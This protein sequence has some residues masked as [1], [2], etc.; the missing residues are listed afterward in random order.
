MKQQNP[1]I[2]A[3]AAETFRAKIMERKG[4]L[5]R[6]QELEKMKDSFPYFL[7][8]YCRT[9]DEHDP[10]VS[11]KPFPRHDFVLGVAQL[12]E[13][14]KFLAIQKSRQLMASWICCAFTL[15]KA[16]FTP[17]SLCFVQ[18]KK[19]EDAADRLSRIYQIYFRFPSWLRERFPINLASGR[20]GSALYTDMHFTWHGEDDSLFGV[21]KKDLGELVESKLIRSR[22]KAIPQGGDILR[23]FTSTLI[24]SDEA[25]FQEMASESFTAAA[26]T[27]GKH[28]HV[29]MV[30]T[31]NPGFFESVVRDRELR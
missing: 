5:F 20:P 14:E 12:L 27:L 19:E 31:A 25:A 28:S 8:N 6:D 17:N 22:I 16:M 1:N 4:E 13:Q 7:F 10:G 11:S 2:R 3:M 26:P 24:F 21:E 18:S 15:W 30:S 29:I 9:Q 23:Q